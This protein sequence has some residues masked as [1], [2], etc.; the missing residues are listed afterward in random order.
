MNLPGLERYN[1]SRPWVYKVKEDGKIASD[2][3]WNIDDGR[4][5][6]PSEGEC[7]KVA[8]K[9]SSTLSFLGLQ[10]AGRKRRGPSYSPGEWPGTMINT[11]LGS[12]KV[13]VSDT[14][15]QTYFFSN[16]CCKKC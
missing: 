2:V 6:A 11:E 16:N 12:T 9:I 5:T 13:L 14:T 3:F 15:I 4:S 8:R 10:D 7:W 1:P